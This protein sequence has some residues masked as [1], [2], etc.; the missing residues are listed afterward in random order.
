MPTIHSPL[1]PECVCCYT[2][3]YGKADGQDT[4]SDS[5]PGKE[6][7]TCDKTNSV[8]K[9]L[10]SIKPKETAKKVEGGIEKR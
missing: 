6:K 7:V 9:E 4:Q 3:S 10:H 5:H 1:L 8:V 2:A